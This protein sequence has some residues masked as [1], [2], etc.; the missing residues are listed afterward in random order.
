MYL[1]SDTPV[2]LPGR[3]LSATVQDC[4][5]AGIPNAVAIQIISV[6]RYK[7]I[8]N[9][10]NG[11]VNAFNTNSGSGGYRVRFALDGE[12]VDLTN[13][14]NFITMANGSVRIGFEGSLL[15]MNNLGAPQDRVFH[16]GNTWYLIEPEAY[17]NVRDGYTRFRSCVGDRPISDSQLAS[18]KQQYYNTVNSNID[19]FAENRRY[20]EQN[21]VA[22]ESIS[23][24]SGLLKVNLREP[25]FLPTYTIEMDASR[26][27]II[28]LSGTPNI[29]QCTEDYTFNEAGSIRR[30]VVVRNTASQAGSF[31]FEFVCTTPEFGASVSP[32]DFAANEQKTI[33]FLLNGGNSGTT[34]NTG[35]CT[36]TVTDRNSQRS[37]SCSFDVAVEYRSGIQQC[38][39]NENYCSPDGK[40]VISCAGGNFVT[41]PCLEQC[42][43]A[44]GISQCVS[45]AGG[46]G[47]GSAPPVDSRAICEQKAKD[48]PLLG[49]TYKESTTTSCGANVLCYAKI[50]KP[51]TIVTGSCTAA[52]IPYYT[53]VLIFA[54]VAVIVLGM[55]GAFK[56]SK[57]RRKRRR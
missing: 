46:A 53:M 11:Y 50:V 43:L 27:G 21:A 14:N 49:Y 30:D 29:V 17:G 42:G 41:T 54:I 32:A 9:R 36:L 38:A 20:I 35:S 18:C 57:R 22:I 16:V 51:K 26:V 8:V 52:F 1:V 12:T 23:F 13:Q 45:S 34:T 44:G 2:D 3:H 24:E 28:R 48:S 56:K 7:C 31:N 33:S 40:S 39:G 37:D 47:S 4:I 10:I 25:T 15:T 6:L 55:Y 5:D 19:P